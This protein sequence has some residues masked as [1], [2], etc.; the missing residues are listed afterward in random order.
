[1]QAI[2]SLER[3]Q[4]GSGPPKP[5]PSEPPACLIGRTEIVVTTGCVNL[6]WNALRR[7]PPH[8]GDCPE[9]AVTVV[10]VHEAGIWSQVWQPQVN[11]G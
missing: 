3:C 6:N 11:W 4:I 5:K 10:P 1:M 2:Q 9:N 7:P 8:G